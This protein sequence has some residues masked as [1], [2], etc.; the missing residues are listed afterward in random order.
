MLVFL[1]SIFLYQ[2]HA[3]VS[4]LHF[5]FLDHFL[6]FS[7]NVH[8]YLL[9]YVSICLCGSVGSGGDLHNNQHDVPENLLDSLSSKTMSNLNSFEPPSATSS[10][11]N[12]L[13]KLSNTCNIWDFPNTSLNGPN[14]MQGQSFSSNNKLSNSV[15]DWSIAPPDPEVNLPFD[16]SPMSLGSSSTCHGLCGSTIPRT[17]YG[18]ELEA[19]VGTALF[20]RSPS[21]YSSNNVLG[22]GFGPTNTSIMAENSRYYGG[23]A[24]SLCRGFDDDNTSSSFGSRIGR[25]FKTLNLSDCKIKPVSSPLVSKQAGEIKSIRFYWRRRFIYVCFFI[26]MEFFSLSGCDKQVVHHELSDLNS[27]LCGFHVKFNRSNSSDHSILYLST[28][29][30][31]KSFTIS[32]NLSHMFGGF[33]L[34]KSFHLSSLVWFFHSYEQELIA[35]MI[36]YNI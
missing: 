2:T 7:K 9:P 27:N 18:S 11:N 25:R 35:I 32:R 34:N 19:S 28:I 33:A 20:R 12:Y 17:Q 4:L 1:W 23:V 21:I 36:F 24:G 13:K 16:S 8:I 14:F 26:D 5:T 6:Y 31:S 15:G 29:M 3:E 30:V 22:D 10:C